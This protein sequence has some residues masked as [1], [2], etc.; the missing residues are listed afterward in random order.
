[1]LILLNGVLEALTYIA[2]ENKENTE[3]FW[4]SLEMDEKTA[5]S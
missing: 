1:M 2:T 5:S 3:P 4:C